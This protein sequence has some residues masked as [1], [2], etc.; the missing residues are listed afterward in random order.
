MGQ[1][2]T[3]LVA[4]ERPTRLRVTSVDRGLIHCDELTFERDFGLEVDPVLGPSL[5]G[6]VQSRLQPEPRRAVRRTIRLPAGTRQVLRIVLFVAYLIVLVGMGVAISF[7]RDP[8]ALF[9]GAGLALIWVA[10]NLASLERLTLQALRT[11]VAAPV[12]R[13]RPGP[14]AEG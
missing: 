1:T 9:L 14:G 12:Q 5:W 6:T 7:D 13:R 4:G 10:M 8:L 11:R 2:V 3:R